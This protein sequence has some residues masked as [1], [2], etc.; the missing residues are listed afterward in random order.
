M[1]PWG[2]PARVRQLRGEFR[3]RLRLAAI[4]QR[5]RQDWQLYVLLAPLL[6]WFLVFLYKPMLGIRIAFKDYSLFLGL[7]KSPWI[8]FENFAALFSDDQFLRAVRNTVTISAYSL[9]LAFPVPILLAL[10]F[11]EIQ[12]GALRRAAQVITYLPHFISVVIIAGLVVAL[13]SPSTGPVNIIR[14]GLGLEPVYFL[15]RPEYFRTIFIGSNIW[16]EAGFESIIY[17]AAISGISP[18]LYEAARLDGATRLQMI[19]YITLPS[20][21]PVILVMLIIRV[22]NLIEVG[23]EYIVLLYQPATFDT[24]D[25]I[26]TYIYRVGLQSNDYGLA[27]AAGLINAVVALVLVYGANRFSRRFSGGAHAGSKA[28]DAKATGALW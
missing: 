24:S 6:I 14:A 11:N 28:A 20:I 12:S 2:P 21:L 10:M 7:A 22:G 1:Q 18:S 8:G 4:A 9:L 15:T 13:A 23:F 25:V 19:R 16:K 5:L 17:L 3:P 27:A 26:S